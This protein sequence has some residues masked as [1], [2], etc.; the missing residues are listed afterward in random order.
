MGLQNP[1]LP[2]VNATAVVAQI[3]DS[4]TTGGN[5]RGDRA[6]DFQQS[7][8]AVTQV[9]SGQ[10]AF[11]GGGNGNTA[12]GAQASVPGGDGNTASQTYSNVSGGQ[13]NTASGVRAT[14][15]GGGT[16]T[17][18]GTESTICGGSTHTADGTNSTVIGGLRAST[19]GTMGKIAYASGGVS[20]VVGSAQGALH[21]LRITSTNATIQRLTS[22]GSGASA[23]NVVPLPDNG[24][25]GF[26]IIVRAQQTGGVAGT[27]G[28][29]ATFK[30]YCQMTRRSG[31]ATTTFDGGY[32]VAPST[33]LNTAIVAGTG[34]APVFATGA[35]TAWRVTV[36]TDTTNGGIQISGTGEAQKNITWVANVRT[37]E[38]VG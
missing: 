12:S 38:V 15:G 11:L 16:N 17:A 8:S 9:A 27:A 23:T 14:V 4:A 13:N 33:F 35:A 32:Y 5:T 2:T 18:S 30:A 20:N 21:V 26:E 6:V 10:R 3:P 37:V 1:G 25:Y 36:N 34:F 22:D 24:G 31:V 19:R 7:R 28:D 29:G